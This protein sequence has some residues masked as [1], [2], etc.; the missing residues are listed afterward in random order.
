MNDSG[1]ALISRLGRNLL[2]PIAA[3]LAGC[4]SA[5]SVDQQESRLISLKLPSEWEREHDRCIV[6]PLCEL[7]DGTITHIPTNVERPRKGFFDNVYYESVQQESAVTAYS[8]FAVSVRPEV[9]SHILLLKNSKRSSGWVVLRLN[10]ET[11]QKEDVVIELSST[12]NFV[13][14]PGHPE[15]A[16]ITQLLNELAP[17]EAATREN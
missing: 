1:T 15:E 13:R 3:V 2:F 6:V 14:L 10:R 4:S 11:L 17:D 9:V 8:P 12:E 5:K 16:R 7:K